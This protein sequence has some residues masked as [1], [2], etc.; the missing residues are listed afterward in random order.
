MKKTAL[1]LML[2]T[3]LSKLMGFARDIT[4]SYFYGASS[5]TDAYLISIT[6]PTVIFVF[7]G[8][9]IGTGYIPMYGNIEMME[10]SK[11][12]DKYTNN[13]VHIIIMICT[14]LLVVG[15]V[16]AVPLVKLFA[17]GFGGETL[18]LAVR[19]TKLGLV[20]I[21]FTGLIS[22]FNGFLQIKGN[23]AIPA[24]IGFPMNFFTILAIIISSNGNVMHLA[25]GSVIATGSQ[26]LLV[27][28]FVYK[29]GFKYKPVFDMKDKHIKKMFYIALPVI[30]GVSINQINVLV[31]RTI[32]S[33]VAIGGI[34]ALDYA[35]KL[36][37]SVHGI[38][39]LSITTVLYPIISKMGA[40]NNMN[41]FK[42]SVSE[43]IGAINLLVIP[44]SLGFMVFAEPIVTLLYGRG[45]FDT[46]AIVMTS[47]ALFFYSIGML[48]FGLREVLARAFYSLQ[49]TKTPA[50]N[51]AIAVVMNAIFSIL[52]SKFMGISGLA[53]G[54][55]ISALFSTVLLFISLRKKIGPFGIKKITIS[56]AKIIG[57]SLVMGFIAKLSFNALTGINGQ[58]LSL[59]ISI[60]I[61]AAV[62][63]VIIYFMRIDTVDVLVGTLKKKL[64]IG[65]V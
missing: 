63:F 47:G 19:F 15:L 2:I 54:T 61:G 49:D 37:V 28:P 53:S 43:A 30:M 58:N 62:Y 18:D 56:F 50:V 40:E 16:F 22:I 24:L 32:A 65:I 36:I 64:G 55:S 4:L 11:E 25:I 5:I 17:S 59:I 1:I 10:G 26:L 3:I 31:D 57:A 7:I 21:Y 23:Y 8:E 60:G 39:V 13:L 9:G 33:R 46:E 41:G 20:G 48:G 42:K 44:I 34:T 35:N 29:K 27:L 51:A 45:K 6:I 14:V 52:L 38:F 12:A